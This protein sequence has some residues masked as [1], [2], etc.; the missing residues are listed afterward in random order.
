VKRIAAWIF[1]LVYS[2]TLFPKRI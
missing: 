1:L 2:A